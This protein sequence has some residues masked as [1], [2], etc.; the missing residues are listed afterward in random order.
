MAESGNW[1]KLNRKIFDNPIVCKSHDMFF[2]W[3]WLL[4]HVCYEKTRVYFRGKDVELKL[5]QLFTTVAKLQAE[6]GLTTMQVR[7]FLE[8]LKNNKQINTQKS[9]KGQVITVLNWQSYQ[10]KQQAKQQTSNK[11]ITNEQQTSNKPTNIQRIKECKEVEEVGEKKNCDYDFKKLIAFYENNIHP[12]SSIVEKESLEDMLNEFGYLT[13]EKAIKRAIMRGKFNIGYINGIL[14][15]WKQ[16]GMDE[17]K[18]KEKK[19]E[20]T[21]YDDIPF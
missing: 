20:H 6:C 9:N 18:P 12:V 7:S 10:S 15:G 19:H 8:L 2:F 3:C 5:G 1:F 21:E 14:S 16:N 17:E 11:P 13:C 4:G